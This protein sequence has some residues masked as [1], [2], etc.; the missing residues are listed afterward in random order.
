MKRFITV[1]A[2]FFLLTVFVCRPS[3]AA[4][5]QNHPDA[6]TTGPTGT[7]TTQ[8]GNVTLGNN[9]NLQ[10]VTLNG[11]ITVN[12][13]PVTIKNVKVNCGGGSNASINLTGAAHDV[14][15]ENVE[16]VRQ[17]A[18]GVSMYIEDSRN[19]TVRAVDF[20]NGGDIMMIN[21]VDGLTIENSYLHDPIVSGNGHTDVI[22][23]V[24]GKNITIRNNT[25]RLGT[26]G[27]GTSGGYVANVLA[28]ADLKPIDNITIDNNFGQGGSAPFYCMA[29]ND[30]QN[31]NS[32]GQFPAPTNC[33][34]T[35]NTIVTGSYTYTTPI[36]VNQAA[37]ELI[38]C[39]KLSD[40]SLAKIARNDR[41]GGIFTNGCTGGVTPT[42]SPGVTI[43]QQPSCPKKNQGDANCDGQITLSDY[44][45]WRNEFTGSATS[46]NA[47]FNGS[48]SV[49]LADYA[50]WRSGFVNPGQVTPGVTRQPGVDPML[51]IT[52][53]SANH[54]SVVMENSV[55]KVTYSYTGENGYGEFSIHEWINKL[56]GNR[57]ITKQVS[58]PFP[59]NPPGQDYLNEENCEQFTGGGGKE[60]INK[61]QMNGTVIDDGTASKTVR[62]T[63]DC[64]ITEEFTIFANSPVLKVNYVSYTYDWID[65]RNSRNV[66]IPTKST[67]VAEPMD[68]VIY[69]SEQWLQTN[70]YLCT[71]NENTFCQKAI[72]DRLGIGGRND[73]A[74]GGPL[75]YKGNFV[76]GFTEKAT[77]IGY[78]RVLPV[79]RLGTW[80]VHINESYEMLFYSL[81]GPT[82]QG[83]PFTGYLFMVTNGPSDLLSIGKSA[84]DG[85][86]VTR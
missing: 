66:Q 2:I 6:S 31:S 68:V 63:Q 48:G 60:N 7:L 52:V 84:V 24:G 69:G 8:N 58:A 47:D 82:S 62:I 21:G 38:N 85:T 13:G 23:F 67:A 76:F 40:G 64:G 4:D 9:Q 49:T 44:A 78:G 54:G 39:N 18:S 33:H 1:I 74:D 34:I 80:W 71:G 55:M 45:L 37:G 46:K 14:L 19:V 35:N 50:V 86:I 25:L 15:V 22:Q 30:P 43:T 20:S 61:T 57:D 81:S 51:K 5:A 83:P 79:N 36:I 16:E 56:A 59:G 53:S 27:S 72:Y 3:Y 17:T 75:S 26:G 10:N 73:P 41:Q 12:G 11:C 28:K 65:N 32:S 77:G 42:V 70:S 29:G